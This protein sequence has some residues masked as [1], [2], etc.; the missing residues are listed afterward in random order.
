MS[1]GKVVLGV[2]AG[3]AAGAAIGILFAPDKGSKTRRK[4]IKKGKHYKDELGDKFDE[5][6]ESITTQF[7]KVK[8]EARHMFEN[9][10]SK[11]EELAASVNDRTS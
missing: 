10:K 8:K 1:T 11:T 2:L 6:I 9:G 7:D 5:F 4:I 3:V